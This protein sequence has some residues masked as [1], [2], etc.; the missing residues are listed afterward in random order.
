[1]FLKSPIEGCA[2]V[3][4]TKDIQQDEEI[5]VNYGKWYWAMMK[6]TKL[7]YFRHSQLFEFGEDFRH[8]TKGGFWTYHQG[9]GANNFGF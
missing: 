6:P 8:V 1:M 3:I 2:W 9:G 7:T 5:F 4:A